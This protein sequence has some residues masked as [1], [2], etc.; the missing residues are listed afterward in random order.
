MKDIR[1]P[2][3]NGMLEL[4][5]NIHYAGKTCVIFCSPLDNVDFIMKHFSRENIGSIINGEYAIFE[6]DKSQ[7]MKICNSVD[8]PAYALVWENNEFV[9][10]SS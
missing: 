8:E 7:A 10:E 9:H 2:D 5:M 3:W 6:C 1:F 4:W